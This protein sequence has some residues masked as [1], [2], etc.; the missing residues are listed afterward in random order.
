MRI[1][2][3]IGTW[4]AQATE[5]REVLINCYVRNS[6]CDLPAPWLWTVPSGSSRLPGFHRFVRQKEGRFGVRSET[7][8]AA[9]GCRRPPREPP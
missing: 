7:P 8:A 4:P 9:A 5:S 2:E 3:R 1:V 6:R